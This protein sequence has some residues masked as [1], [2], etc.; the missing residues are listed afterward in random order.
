MEFL[1]IKNRLTTAREASKI[2]FADFINNGKITDYSK[3]NGI[4]I[5]NTYTNITL[6]EKQRQKTEAEQKAIIIKKEHKR[7]DKKAAA[8]LTRIVEIENTT[9]NAG[10]KIDVDWKKSAAW[11]YCPNANIYSWN[12][13]ASHRATAKAGGC[14]YDKLSSVT[15]DLLN[16]DNS[17][18]HI[19]L[20]AYEKATAAD[21][22]INDIRNIL[23]YG[24]SGNIID[25]LQ[26]FDGGVGVDCHIAILKKL[27]YNVTH[28]SGGN[29]DY[30]EAM[31]I[32][33][34]DGQK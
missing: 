24:I 19:V 18:L 7:I 13:E 15:A 12:Y 17:I 14:G 3:H 22:T 20:T 5:D 8:I 34:E 4:K 2:D 32:N 25:G 23:G 28:N 9:P 10:F 26:L 29:Y 11:G 27:G 1:N 6:T 31:Y 30:I 33:K 21:N 16:S